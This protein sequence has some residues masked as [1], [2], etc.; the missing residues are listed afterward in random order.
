MITR[1]F[2]FIAV[3]LLCLFIQ[4]LILLFLERFTPPVIANMI[5][6]LV[7]AQLNFILSYRYTWSDS[8]RKNGLGLVATWFQFNLVVLLSAC[9]NAVA[10]YLIS[11]LL[12]GLIMPAAVG[13]ISN[14][15]AAIGATITSTVCTFAINHL[16]V[17]KP[18]KR[19]DREPS[20]GNSNVP[21]SVE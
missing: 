19:N 11:Y 14:V 8:A 21:A 13:T 6:F 20:T 12:V 10:F 9:I 1:L 15:V 7:S 4:I 3:G 18:E 16:V 17:L 2:Q 5:G